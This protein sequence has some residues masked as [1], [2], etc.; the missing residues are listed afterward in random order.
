MQPPA[1]DQN[2]GYGEFEIQDEDDPDDPGIPQEI[3]QELGVGARNRNEAEMEHPLLR[4]AKEA[5]RN[6][7]DAI[8]DELN[9][10]VQNQNH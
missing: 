3:E 6:K 2:R 7:R 10:H 9:V 4:Q 8:V 5:G 1:P